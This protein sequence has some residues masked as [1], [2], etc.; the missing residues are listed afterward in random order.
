[1]IKRLATLLLGIGLIGLGILFFVAPE[2]ILIVQLFLRYWPLFLILA[3]LVRI[4][5]YLIDRHPTSPVGGM[6]VTAIGG[7]LLTSN[8]R[9]ESSFIQIFGNYWFWLLLALIMGRVLLQYAHRP[10]D[11]PRPRAFS[12]GAVVLM[13]LITG[14]GLASHYVSKNNSLSNHLNLPISKLNQYRKYIISDELLTETTAPQ[15]FALQPDSRLIINN[16]SG[17]IVVTV[18][19]QSG[20]SAHLVNRIRAANEEEAKQKTQNIRLQIE[21]D[22]RNYRLT[23]NTAKPQEDAETTLFVTLPRNVKVG[24]DV[25]NAQGSVKLS[26]LRGDHTIRNCEHLEVAENV[27]RL[28]VGNSRGPVEL[29]DIQGEV[30]LIK[31]DRDVSLR[32]ITGAIRINTEGGDVQ[33]EDAKGSITVDATG[34]IEV[35]NFGGALKATT[36][37][38][39]INLSTGER[40]TGDI[41]AANEKGRIRLSLPAD[42]VFRLDAATG[43]GRIKFR[44]FDQI[45]LQHHERS[46]AIGY[47][48]SDTAPLINLRSGRGSI[49]VQA[50]GLALASREDE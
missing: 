30:D 8:L 35:Q 36:R 34:D 22:D 32:R 13:V 9:G 4:A 12:P 26:G 14:G 10:A 33:I 5:G 31:T 48:I 28:A 29:T 25:D 6:M 39:A 2:R 1:M 47:N 20:A 18:A 3:G 37:K 19:P 23:V 27:G 15:S 41:K 43:R 24:L 50:S 11:G 7:V 21:P 38:G 40:I 17:D 45:N 44:G 42:S 16:S 49:Q 46:S